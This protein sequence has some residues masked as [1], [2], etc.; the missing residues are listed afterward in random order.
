MKRVGVLASF[1]LALAGLLLPKTASAQQYYG[2][3]YAQ[4]PYGYSNGYDPRAPY[5]VYGYD[6]RE[7]WREHEWRER[8]ERRE[9]EWRRREW[10][11]HERWERNRWRDRDDWRY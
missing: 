7:A 9:R 4:Q 8:E 1:V 2:Q 10:R 6:R 3:Y 5:G 11:E